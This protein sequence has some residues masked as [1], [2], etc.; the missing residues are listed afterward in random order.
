[1]R[2]LKL[3]WFTEDPWT[4]YHAS[5]GMAAQKTVCGVFRSTRAILRTETLNYIVPKSEYKELQCSKC[6]AILRK[7]YGGE[8]VERV[9]VD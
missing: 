1:M 9:K 7:R 4:K 6:L 2:Y 8:D 3:I 5:I